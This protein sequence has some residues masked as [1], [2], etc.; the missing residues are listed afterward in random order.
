MLILLMNLPC[1]PHLSP[2]VPGTI[3]TRSLFLLSNLVLRCQYFG[4]YSYMS[5]LVP[6]TLGTRA[7]FS[8]L[9][10]LPLA[11]LSIDFLNQLDDLRIRHAS[12]TQLGDCQPHAPNP[13]DLVCVES[14]GA[15]PVRH[16]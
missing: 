11:S 7:L 5:P 15:A 14:A 4:F 12:R 2:N 9:N 3:G 16:R 1:C 13:L 10:S 8:L 6:G